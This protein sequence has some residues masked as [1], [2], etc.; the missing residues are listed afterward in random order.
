MHARHLVEIAAWT[1]ANAATIADSINQDITLFSDT[2][3]VAHKSRSLRWSL[4]LKT[5]EKDLVA[6]SARHNPWPALEIIVEEIV[7]AEVLT[8]VWAA[9]MVSV[10]LQHQRVNYAPMAHSIFISHIEVRNRVMRLLLAAQIQNEQLFNRVNQLRKMVEKWTDLL[11]GMFPDQRAARKFAFDLER[12]Q[13]HARE[14][15]LYS[16]AELRQRTGILLGSIESSFR[17]LCNKWSANP[18]LNRRVVDGLI[19]CV[20]PGTFDYNHLPPVVAQVW[21]EKSHS[22]T[23]ILVE[24]LAQL[25]AT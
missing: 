1:A 13:D 16:S 18:E 5:F 9:V 15:R 7:A 19:A 6:D 20:G 14:Q 12:L 8:R 4:A 10:D 23:E 17:S 21:S 25:E 11:L 3:W 24:R 22:E 2:Y